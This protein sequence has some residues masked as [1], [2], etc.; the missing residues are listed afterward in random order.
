VILST[1]I[2]KEVKAISLNDRYLDLAG[3]AVYSSMSVQSLRTHIRKSNLP[4]FR[5]DGKL[6][7]KRSEYDRWIEAFRLHQE[8]D[9]DQKVAEI[10]TAF[11]RRSES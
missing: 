11:K 5:V 9:I 8:Q 1:D 2:V 3:L 6:F 10:L 7:V 4:A